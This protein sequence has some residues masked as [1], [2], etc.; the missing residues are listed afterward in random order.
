M[1]EV[2]VYVGNVT[3]VADVGQ[4]IY[5]RTTTGELQKEHIIPYGL[6][7]EH[8]L[9]HAS[10]NSCADI[11]KGF[12]QK[13]LRNALLE[14]RT[15]LQLQTRR[16]RERPTHFRLT[17]ERNGQE[18]LIQVP[19]NQ[20]LAMLTLPLFNIP[21]CLDKRPYSHGIEVPGARCVQV[22]GKPTSELAEQYQAS[23]ITIQVSYEVVA[24]ARMLAKIAYG[25]AVAKYGLNNRHYQDSCTL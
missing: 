25:F 14:S 2:Q 9:L 4:C 24:F 22:A 18:E 3:V 13:V 16:P 15:G 19:A 7:G 23:A 1:N 11:T 10:C 5:C 20:H 17:V 6:N 21:A 8:L 12:E